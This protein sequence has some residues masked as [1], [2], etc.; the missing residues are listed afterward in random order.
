[1]KKYFFLAIL[2]LSLVACRKDDKPAMP[3]DDDIATVSAD[4][5]V[6]LQVNAGIGSM[7]TRASG[8]TWAEGDQIGI[9]TTSVGATSYSN[10]P[11]IYSSSKF[12]ANTTPIYFQD[13]TETVTFSAYYPYV[14]SA[15]YSDVSTAADAQTTANQPNI[16]FL[17]ASGA[18]A[19]NS[20]PTATFTFTHRMSQIALQFTEGDGVDLDSKLTAYT[21]TG[22]KLSGSFDTTTGEATATATEASD[23]EISLSGV[24]TSDSKYSADPLI[25]FPQS[26]TSITLAVTVDGQTYNA[27]LT[28][29]EANNSTGLVAGY[30]YVFPVTVNK[31]SLV[32]GTATI[33]DWTTVTAGSVNATM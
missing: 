30:S 28:V 20:N 31:G 29:P 18:T 14:E 9:S 1:M 23:L 10:M 15:T 7:L 33:T 27:T 22:L 3:A 16:D 13:A 32:V 8:T 26:T 2:A 17:Y 4:D 21:L 5:N 11:Y 19:S 6:A 12:S 25:V 24:T